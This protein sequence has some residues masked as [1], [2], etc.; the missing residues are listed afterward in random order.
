[1]GLDMYLNSRVYHSGIT[2]DEN[3]KMRV[4]EL[5]TVEGFKKK[6]TELEIAYWRKHPNL[7]GYI[8]NTFNKGVDN[9]RP[10]ELTPKHLDQIADAIEKNELPYTNGSFFGS[11]EDHE[12]G[13]KE[14]IKIFRDASTW[15]DKKLVEKSQHGDWFSIHYEAS[16]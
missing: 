5:E 8:V 10:I 4:R 7:H 15:L 6:A 14:N 1:M 16:W 2:Y 3:K 9:C 13:K 12:E 11:S